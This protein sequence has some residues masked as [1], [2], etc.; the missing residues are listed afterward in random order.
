VLSKIP[1]RKWAVARQLLQTSRAFGIDPLRMA[2][3][4]ADIPRSIHA[5]VQYKTRSGNA[6]SF[7][8]TARAM[9]LCL[10]DQR[11]SAGLLDSHYFYQDLWA[12]RKIHAAQPAF[13]VDVG[14]RIDGFIAHLLCFTSVTVIDIRPKPLD[15]AGLTFVQDDATDL[16][17]FADASVDSISSLHA[18]E[19]FG[20][21]RYG[22]PVDPTASMRAMKSLQRVLAYNG[23]LYF[24]VPIG[25]ERLEFNAHRVFAPAS[26]LSAF[27]RLDLVSFSAVD[28]D[29]HF[30]TDA[31]PDSLTASEYACGLFEFTKRSKV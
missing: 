12:A 14:S 19:H 5:A 26:I 1:R 13:H 31:D 16:V 20:L 15:V 24:A 8:L 7:P 18:I 29:R 2:F 10:G 25:R 11:K 28:D 9:Y 4:I 22:D 23:R 21:G 3:A 30:L 17:R 6:P 27:S